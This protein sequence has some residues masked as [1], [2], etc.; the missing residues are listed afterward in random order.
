MKLWQDLYVDRE[1]ADKFMARQFLLFP[2]NLTE[3]KPDFS[4]NLV[5]P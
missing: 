5:L 3:V 2:R 1:H 4:K